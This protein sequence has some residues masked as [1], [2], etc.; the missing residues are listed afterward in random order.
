MGFWKLVF[1]NPIFVNHINMKPITADYP[2][3]FH[4]Y[5]SLVEES[6]IAEGLKNQYQ[7]ALN[8]LQS[9]T[10]QKSTFTYAPGKWTIKQMMQHI[11]DAERIF[12]Y[13]ALCIA[14]G[15]QQKLPGFDENEYA[16]NSNADVRKWNDLLNEFVSVRASTKILYHSFTENMLS[17]KGLSNGNVITVNSLGFITAGHLQH[18]INI[19]RERYL[20]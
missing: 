16:A 7:P 5:I 3:P 20:Q 19:L 1:E 13:R 15:E 12:S 10:E 17:S 2:P 11:I 4:R 9:I 14:R 8:L 18:H 6:T